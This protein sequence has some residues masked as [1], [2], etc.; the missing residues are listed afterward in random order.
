MDSGNHRYSNKSFTC[1]RI[2]AVEVNESWER[3]GS[4]SLVYFYSVSVSN[5]DTDKLTK[6]CNS[7]QLLILREAK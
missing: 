2:F 5:V 1:F 4:C 7:R 3:R 6:T